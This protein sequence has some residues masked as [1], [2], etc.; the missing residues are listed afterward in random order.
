MVTE[1]TTVRTLPDDFDADEL[2]A[3]LTTN[4]GERLPG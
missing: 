1:D 2:R 3:M 4:G